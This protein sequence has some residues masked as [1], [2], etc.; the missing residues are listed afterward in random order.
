MR[1]IIGGAGE[2]GCGLAKSLI[3]EGKVVVLIDNNPMAVKN[4]QMLDALVIQ[5][6]ITHRG[7]LED[8]GIADA[9]AFVAATESDEKNLVA[10]ALAK[11]TRS[12]LQGQ[13]G[14][15]DDQPAAL[16][17]L[18]QAPRHSRA[19]RKPRHVGRQHGRDREL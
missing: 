8:A 18:G 7:K 19:D 12:V 16:D 9:R 1:I 2:V 15:D 5:G 11:H 6:D 10:C 4:A 3:A 14:D 17:A 13:V